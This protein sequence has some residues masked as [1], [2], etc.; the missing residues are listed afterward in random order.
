MNRAGSVFGRSLSFPLRVGSD[1]RLVWSQGEDNIRESI[2][3]IL[4]TEP[5]ERVVLAD[6][7]AGLGHFLFEPNTATTH[8]RIEQ[9]V[10]N[11]LARWEQRIS[12]ESVDVAPDATQLDAALA[13]ITYRLVVTG[14]LERMSV[15]IPLGAS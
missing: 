11:A 13:T 3:V 10:K 9:A 14:G 4:K 2:A 12:V 8:A 15:S 5:G 1:G 7:G 6:F